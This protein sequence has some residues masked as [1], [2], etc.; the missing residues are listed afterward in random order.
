MSSAPS[1]QARQRARLRRSLAEFFRASWHVLEPST[2]L[3]WGWHLDELCGH[4]QAQLEGWARRQQDPTHEQAIKDLLATLPP[5]TAKSKA[6]V[7]ASAWAWARWPTI[8]I[9]ALSG[10]PRVAMRDSM[11]FRQLVTSS[12]YVEALAPTWTIRDDMDAKGA[13]GNSAR[14]RAARDGMWT[15]ER[16]ANTS[17]GSKPTI[18][19]TPSRSSRTPRGRGVL[20]RWDGSWANRVV[21]LAS[22]IRIG[23]AQRTGRASD[24]SA[25]RIAEGWE[26]ST[27]RC[28]SSPTARARR[29]LGT[30]DHRTVEGECLHPA[31]FTPEVITEGASS[32]RRA[33][34]GDALSGPS[35]AEGWRDDQARRPPVLATRR[36]AAGRGSS[37][38]AATPARRSSCRRASTRS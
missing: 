7:I 2:P 18:R 35:R 37:E 25:A 32:R 23:I 22:S 5:G 14:W 19:T 20:D 34:V 31:R 11:L 29:P 10:N 9:L 1:R 6:L 12:W 4:V 24:W 26:H 33:P 30:P 36:G 38:G 15:R 3:V 27:C 8:K 28:S 17:T 13:I 21:D 16:S